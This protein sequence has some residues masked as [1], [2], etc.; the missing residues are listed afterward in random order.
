MYRHIH[1][2]IHVKIYINIRR[3]VHIYRERFVYIKDGYMSGDIY[4]NMGYSEDGGRY[5][6]RDGER[7]T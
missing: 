3:C 6:E 5:Q 4:I 2:A 1:K 7:D